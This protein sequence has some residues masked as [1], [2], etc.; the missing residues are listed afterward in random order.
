MSDRS[1]SRHVSLRCACGTALEAEH[2]DVIDEICRP[3][4]MT[5]L[6]DGELGRSLCTRCGRVQ[7][8][9]ASFGVVRA[10]LGGEVVVV[11]SPERESDDVSG[12]I[13]H[14]AT[15]L[16]NAKF[17]RLPLDAAPTV[18]GRNLDSDVRDVDAVTAQ[19]G[20]GHGPEIAER[21]R[22]FLLGLV[23]GDDADNVVDVLNLLGPVTDYAGLVATL[24]RHPE[25]LLQ[26]TIDLLERAQLMIP[27]L[28]PGLDAM[29]TLL[30]A[31]RTEPADAWRAYAAY[32]REASE[33]LGGF[34]PIVDQLEQ[35]VHEGRYDEVVAQGREAIENAERAGGPLI[36]G[37]IDALVAEAL[38][39]TLSG[40][41]AQ[42]LEAA[43]HHYQQAVDRSSSDV[44][45]RR[46]G[47]LGLAYGTRVLGDPRENLERAIE[48]MR[49]ALSLL[50]GE[51]DADTLALIQTNLAQALERRA[52]GDRRENLREA[53]A[54]CK[55]ALKRR[56]PQRNATNWAYSQVNLGNILEKMAGASRR[57]VSEARRAYEAVIAREDEIPDAKVVGNAYYNL[58]DIHRRKAL[59]TRRV[60]RKSHHL[61]HAQQALE[62][63]QLLCENVDPILEGR[64]LSKLADIHTLRDDSTAVV[65]S[66]RA[67]SAVLRPTLAPSEAE[68]AASQLGWLLA[69]QGDWVGAADA[70][71]DAL[72]AARLSYYSR[73]RSVDRAADQEDRT[74][75]SRW[76]A[77][78]LVRADRASDALLALEDGRTR[79][80]RRRLSPP[81]DELDRLLSASPQL[82]ARYVQA[83]ADLAHAT[84]G[85]DGEGPVRR[86][87]QALRAVQMLPG[88]GGFGAMANLSSIAVAISPETP[89]I[90]VDPT[91]FGTLLLA[92]THNPDGQPKIH[93]TFLEVTSKE[94]AWRLMFGI[95][96]GAQAGASFLAALT[97]GNS[98]QLAA[99]LDF[100]LPWFGT[101]LAAPINAQIQSL[102]V[103][104]A[105]LI[106]MGPL[107]L[108]PLHAEPSWV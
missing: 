54:L 27:E 106:V 107:A 87:E 50:S 21:Y 10:A 102:G 4:L 90:Y 49:A 79:E 16:P 97:A 103:E 12:L 30:L 34:Q 20:Q 23:H 74:T 77:Y 104:A 17:T 96:D 15:E 75:L 3:D 22:G 105:N 81:D 84:L 92:V 39:Q 68:G 88:F 108:V 64:A 1:C 55:A 41:H 58:A 38:M 18:L 66:L 48:T 8:V 33:K 73:T 51:S 91:P 44:R 40:E 25:L 11:F 7:Y 62:H 85:D 94:I 71:A 45:G 80:L 2:W 53:Y 57:R 14:L 32:D 13:E 72:D 36:A 47:N 86:H 59:K 98:E 93:T 5:A 56:T 63:A 9:E 19:V 42:N 67:A 43:I 37:V 82:H 26:A 46:L 31:A 24:E 78:T 70:Y 99:A 28:A 61:R 65:N 76:A 35:L 52:S 60:S 101:R 29:H 69:Q 6:L 100:N 83:V 89:L 95:Q